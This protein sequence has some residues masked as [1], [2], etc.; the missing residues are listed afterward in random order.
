MKNAATYFNKL[1]NMSVASRA[2]QNISILSHATGLLLEVREDVR[3]QYFVAN[4][5]ASNKSVEIPFNV[6][7]G[8]KKI[9]RYDMTDEEFYLYTEDGDFTAPLRLIENDVEKFRVIA[10][11]DVDALAEMMYG[12]AT[13]AKKGK[14]PYNQKTFLNFAAGTIS[15]YCGTDISIIRNSNDAEVANGNCIAIDNVIVPKI[16]K[17]LNYANN[18]KNGG[19]DTVWIS[20]CGSS[21]KLQVQNCTIIIPVSALPAYKNIVKKF[22]EMLDYAYAMQECDF[23][24]DDVLAAC[25][26]KDEFIALAGKEMLRTFSADFLN[27][28]AVNDYMVYKLETKANALLFEADRSK[29][30]LMLKENEEG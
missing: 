4:M 23:D 16:K 19:G 11:M 12:A 21:L 27:H 8:R 5:P 17:W 7:Y 25:K 20:I 18:P 22:D 9:L 2:T 14:H 6:I 3:Y 30:L 1:L 29:A 15:A 13:F 24:W 10:K 26:S 28:C